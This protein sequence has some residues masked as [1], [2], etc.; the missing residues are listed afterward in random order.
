MSHKDILLIHSKLQEDSKL[1]E[2]IDKEL[3]KFKVFVDELAELTEILATKPYCDYSFVSPMFNLV[4]PIFRF[5]TL[6]RGFKEVQPPSR[7]VKTLVKRIERLIILKWGIETAKRDLETKLEYIVIS[8]LFCSPTFNKRTHSLFSFYSSG[9]LELKYIPDHTLQEAGKVLN[10]TTLLQKKA[11][12]IRRKKIEDSA[13][14]FAVEDDFSVSMYDKSLKDTV[15]TADECCVLMKKVNTELR[16]DSEFA[17]KY[18]K[19]LFSHTGRKTKA[20]IDLVTGESRAMLTS[21]NDGSLIIGYILNIESYNRFKIESPDVAVSKIFI[22]SLLQSKGGPE[23]SPSVITM[24]PYTNTLAKIKPDVGENDLEVI[25]I[26]IEM[27]GVLIAVRR[28][29]APIDHLIQYQRYLIK[30]EEAQFK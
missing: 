9:G 18:K 25:K 22:T 8:D 30:L 6:L 4:Y 19:V 24:F 28:N 10:N 13:I 11:R 26:L 5:N 7:G 23:I 12:E 14:S 17:L 29:S 3:G 27:L 1:A 20:L 15:L 16:Y 21:A 2:R